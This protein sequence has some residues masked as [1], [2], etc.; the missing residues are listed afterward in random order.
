MDQD[1]KNLNESYTEFASKA[2]GIHPP[3]QDPTGLFGKLLAKFFARP[4]RPTHKPDKELRGDTYKAEELLDTEGFAPGMVRGIHKLP[5]Y[6]YERKKRY[7]EFEDMD[8]FPEI[9]AA[10]DIYADDSSQKSIEGKMINIETPDSYLQS[11]VE[12]LFKKI[13]IEKVLWDII[14][15]T[16]KYGDCFIETIFNLKRPELGIQRLKILN[17]N[18]LLR[19]EN[20]FGYLKNFIQEIPR[21]L[22]LDMPSNTIPKKHIFLDKNQIVHFRIHNS[23]PG[24]YP[25]GKS[26]L[27]SAMQAFRSLRLMEEAMLVYRLTRAP[28]RRVFY[29][30]IGNMP[31]SKA[32][33]FIERQKAKFKKEKFFD[34]RT[35]AVDE[36]YNPLSADEDYFVPTRKDS[37]ASRIE[38]LPGAQ[39]LGEVEDVKYFRDKLLSALKVPKDFI[40]EKDGSP[41]RKANLSQLDVKFARAVVRL[42]REVEIGLTTMVKR[43]LKL[44]R[45]P[46]MSLRDFKIFLSPPSDIYEKRRL[47]LDDNKTRVVQAVKGLQL[48]SDEYLYK[49]YFNMTDKEIED[50]KKKVKEEQMELA[51][52]QAAMQP[53]MDPSMQGMDPSMQGMDPNMIDPN[54]MDPNMPGQP[55][56]GMESDIEGEQLP[57][58]AAPR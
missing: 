47:E 40:V 54:M 34:P 45:F 7:A 36:R 55:S 4:G 57:P 46:S 11:E 5:S 14:R 42:Q 27:S 9:N 15:N 48:F 22:N 39:N 37:K 26:I 20:A 12:S 38:T 29:I 16:A 2:G 3:N 18:Y 35:Q 43:H 10:L 13:E 8:H 21:D 44:R 28:E 25:Y 6:E 50:M 30:D 49:T 52:Q 41:E 32:E 31:A 23:D 53:Q 17:P 51:E 19:A 56:P 24:F 58:Q 1:D 33:A